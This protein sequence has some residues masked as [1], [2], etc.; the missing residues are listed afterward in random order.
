MPGL[1]HEN[2]VPKSIIGI[3]NLRQYCSEELNEPHSYEYIF[4]HLLLDIV[5]DTK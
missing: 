3:I 4:T 2:L 5:E 1:K